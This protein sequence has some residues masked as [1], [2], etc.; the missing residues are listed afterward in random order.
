MSFVV[1]AIISNHVSRL[2]CLRII[3]AP[4]NKL[5]I[6]MNAQK[7][8]A[9]V[10]NNTPSTNNHSKNPWSFK[11]QIA[12]FKAYLSFDK[13]SNRKF[14]R[15]VFTTQD[16][17]NHRSSSRYFKDFLSMPFSLV[18]RGLTLQAVMMMI[19][20]FFIVGYNLLAI[21]YTKAWSYPLP[22]FSL[23][24]LPVSLTSPSL[25]LL[26]VFRTNTAYSRWEK[27][28]ITWSSITAKSFDLMRQGS[29]FI[30]DPFLKTSL[31]RYIIAFSK[32]LKW[33]LGH[34]DKDR[35]LSEDLI[36]ILSTKESV[37]LMS[38]K[39]RVQHII[40]HIGEIVSKSKFV[41]L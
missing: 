26:L 25:G 1:F 24:T 33:L 2:E 39:H 36:G 40:N 35:R 31:F 14:R 18:L 4:K 9:S 12:K 21:K 23:P 3:A 11:V 17:K 27:A 29:L 8:E 13:E 32:T 5:L 7:L 6:F 22:L 41:G 38:S 30:K 19:W 16:W 34:S 10:T 37:K 20:S 15:T 28:S